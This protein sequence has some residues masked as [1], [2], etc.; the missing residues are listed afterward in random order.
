[1]NSRASAEPYTRA[2]TTRVT[3]VSGS[4]VILETTYFYPEGGGQPAD[5]GTI[6]GVDVLD[7]QYR[8]DRVV[9]KLAS[10][11]PFEAGDSVDASVDDTFRTYLMRAHTASHVLYGAGRRLLDNLGYGGF[12][13]GADPN[14]VADGG[15]DAKV[16]V[17]FET[18]TEITDETLLEFERL[19]NRAVWDSRPVSWEQLP[20]EEALAREDVAFNT[21]T[22]E[23]IQGDTVRIVT[24]DGWD[25][26]ACGG[27]HVENT[28]EIGPVT[29]LDRSNPGEGLTRVEF[30]VGP[31]A[32]D[33]R[34]REKE[35]AMTAARALETRIDEL[36]EAVDRVRSERMELREELETLRED[37]VDAHL[38]ELREQSIE[39]N[40][41]TWLV[42]VLSGLDANDLSDHAQ[43]EIGDGADVVALVSDCGSYLAVATTGDVDASEIVSMVTDEFGG[44]G[45]GGPTL[46]Q[47]GGLTAD[48]DEIVAALRESKTT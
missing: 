10:E 28:R 24:V 41:L 26:A 35:R 9:H 34:V 40:G 21:K 23:G 38:A 45:G 2:F 47:G 4:D 20:R 22:E 13:I 17:D 36:P 33:R 11:P 18:S 25:V 44:G 16:R 7:V 19:T 1:M 31:R 5:V 15:H 30:T 37:V 39:K 46:A 12:D 14:D 29:V 32:I 3:D 6:G 42:G 43:E 8:D 27:T 48:G